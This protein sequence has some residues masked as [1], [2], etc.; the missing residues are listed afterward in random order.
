[1]KIKLRKLKLDIEDGEL[2]KINELEFAR[3]VEGSFHEWTSLDENKNKIGW[4][5]E[6]FIESEDGDFDYRIDTKKKYIASLDLDG[7]LDGEKIDID[8]DI[9]LLLSSSYSYVYEL[10]VFHEIS[11]LK[12]VSDIK[13]KA[14]ELSLFPKWTSGYLS[15]NLEN[16]VIIKEFMEIFE[17]FMNEFEIVKKLKINLES[18]QIECK[19]KKIKEIFKDSLKKYI[20]KEIFFILHDSEYRNLLPKLEINK[21]I[22]AG[23]RF[24]P[25][26]DEVEIYS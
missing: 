14:V 10:L 18:I 22:S 6:F 25:K 26:L 11:K 2:E 8:E 17:P 23:H 24:N 12:V 19:N 7:F 20:K 3:L 15:D 21:L 1:M 16:N 13:L 5:G 9:E 4:S